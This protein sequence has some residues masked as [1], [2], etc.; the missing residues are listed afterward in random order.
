MQ[1]AVDYYEILHV[2]PEAP[3]EIIKASYRT[4]MQRLRAHPDLGGDAAKAAVINEAYETLRDGQRR[5]AY[6]IQ[7]QRAVPASARPA[8]KPVTGTCPYCAERATREADCRRCGAPLTPLH[9]DDAA[10]G[11]RTLLRM[12]RRQALRLQHG[13]PSQSA[14]AHT[15]DISTQGML[16]ETREP[17]VPGQMLLLECEACRAIARV[18]HRREEGGLCVAGLEFVT[19]TF[20][21]ARGTFVSATA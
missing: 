18:V 3:L 15:R 16:I 1:P 9:R 8:A 11:A 12:P 4:L 2:H 14:S 13:W 17:L 6:D 20:A 19:V 10:R 21:R 7:R 5:E